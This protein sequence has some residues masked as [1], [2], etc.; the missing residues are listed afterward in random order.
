MLWLLIA[1]MKYAIERSAAIRHLSVAQRPSLQAAR[2]AALLRNAPGVGG[3][4]LA[5]RQDFSRKW[6]LKTLFS[7]TRWTP[8]HTCEFVY[9]LV[10][11]ERSELRFQLTQKHTC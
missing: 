1:T 3:G 9:F 7:Y 5:G 2:C 8:K 11:E 6:V 10:R 4:A